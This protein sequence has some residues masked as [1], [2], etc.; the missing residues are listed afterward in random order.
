LAGNLH[1]SNPARLTWFF[2]FSLLLYGDALG[3]LVGGPQCDGKE[4][5]WKEESKNKKKE[6][7]RVGSL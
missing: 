5:K 2:F 4:R 6:R 1:R 7:A 3:R